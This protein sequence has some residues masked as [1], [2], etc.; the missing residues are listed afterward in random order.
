MNTLQGPVEFDA[1]GDLKNN[2]ISVFQIKKNGDVPLDDPASQ[3]KYM[4]VA[5][6][7]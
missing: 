4:G 1:N 7:V 2:V 5:P 3:Y 6:M